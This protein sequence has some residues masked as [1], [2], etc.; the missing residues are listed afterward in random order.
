M[1]ET[2][3]TH[4][5][6]VTTTGPFTGLAIL[7]VVLTLAAAAALVIAMFQAWIDGVNGDTLAFNAYWKMNPATDVNFWR[8]AALVPLGC[9][10]VGVLGLMTLGGWLTRLAGAVAIVAFGLMVIELARANATLPNDIGAGLW[11]MLGG[12]VV[13]L[14][15]SLATWSTTTN[16]S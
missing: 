3:Q 1:A 16:A 7:R 8:S 11:W 13:M 9:A 4:D 12:G 10:I 14:I 15:G 6:A 2:V 5:E